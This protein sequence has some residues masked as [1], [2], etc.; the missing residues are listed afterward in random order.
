[1]THDHDLL[2]DLV[3]YAGPEHV[4]LGSD[5]P[6][7]MGTDHP[8]EEVRA[9]RLGGHEELVLGRNAARLMGMA[10]D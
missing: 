3:R 4:L 2:A 9:L 7:D 5:R 1:V 10:D 6:F 8:V